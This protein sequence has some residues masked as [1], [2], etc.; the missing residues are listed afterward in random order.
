MRVCSQG[1]AACTAAIAPEGSHCSARSPD[2]CGAASRR[3]PLAWPVAHWMGTPSR[4]GAVTVEH[5][6]PIFRGDFD[7]W[8]SAAHAEVRRGNEEHARSFR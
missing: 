2:L 4:F 5:R 7:R 3:P 1:G 8:A 6:A